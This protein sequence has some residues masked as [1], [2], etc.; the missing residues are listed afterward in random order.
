MLLRATQPAVGAEAPAAHAAAHAAATPLPPTQLQVL[1]AQAVDIGHVGA[2]HHQ[3][4]APGSGPYVM[5]RHQA[6]AAVDDPA[7]AA[8]ATQ[9][10]VCKRCDAC[11]GVV[12]AC[13]RCKAG[14]DVSAV[15]PVLLVALVPP[16]CC[17]VLHMVGT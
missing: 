12:Q 1:V 11:G 7:A 10:L 15:C 3:Q 5:E 16:A 13:S 2:G 6:G 8:G 17:E 4:V 9:L 14:A